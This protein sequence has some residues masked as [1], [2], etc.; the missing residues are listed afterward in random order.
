MILVSKAHVYSLFVENRVSLIEM[1]NADIFTY[2]MAFSTLSR[3]TNTSFT[4]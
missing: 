1:S 4:T 2:T 3:A